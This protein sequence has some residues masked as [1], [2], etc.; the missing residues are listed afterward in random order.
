MVIQIEKNALQPRRRDWP[1]GAEWLERTQQ[2]AWHLNRSPQNKAPHTSQIFVPPLLDRE[3]GKSAALYAPFPALQDPEAESD[4]Y[5]REESSRRFA[6]DIRAEPVPAKRLASDNEVVDPR[7][8]RADHIK[9]LIEMLRVRC[10]QLQGPFTELYA[11]WNEE[12]ASHEELRE[13]LKPLKL[14]WETLQSLWPNLDILW[15]NLRAPSEE[16]RTIWEW[17]QDCLETP[18]DAS[19]MSENV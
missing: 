14:E 15:Q 8:D 10:E 19:S 7:G 12:G 3:K 13:L 17:I 2:I 5:G 6:D 16:W 4:V 9:E 1:T 18:W 11:L